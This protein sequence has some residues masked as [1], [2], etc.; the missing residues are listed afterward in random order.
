MQMLAD[1]AVDLMVV[2]IT[3]SQANRQ[4]IQ[5]LTDV[6][7][8]CRPHELAIYSDHADD[9][10][11]GLRKKIIGTHVNVLLKPL[12]MHGLL[13]LLRKMDAETPLAA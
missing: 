11:T 5:N 4:F 10:L 13:K 3:N 1:E 8:N 12:H 9:S 6:P 7:M 2:D